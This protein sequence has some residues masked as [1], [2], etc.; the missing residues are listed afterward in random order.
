MRNQDN[1]PG[2]RATATSMSFS[3]FFSPHPFANIWSAVLKLHAIRFP[4]R[5]KV[6]CVAIDYANSCQIQNDAAVDCL[7]FKK[8]PQLGRMR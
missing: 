1:S 3:I 2:K 8:S 6:Q 7:Q 5:E 4:N